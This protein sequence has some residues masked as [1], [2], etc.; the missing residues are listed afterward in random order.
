M[1]EDSAALAISTKDQPGPYDALEKARPKEPWFVL[2]GRDIAGPATLT[3]WARVRRNAALKRYGDSDKATDKELLAAELRQCQNAEELAL[4]FSDYRT[5]AEAP[6][7][8]R[9]SYQEVIKSAEEIAAA[10]RLKRQAAA[11]RHLR[12]AAYHFAEAETL[13]SG[14]G[15]L[16]SDEAESIAETRALINGLAEEHEP[17]RPRSASELEGEA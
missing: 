11:G 6:E 15:R 13:L 12:E 2:L 17:K 7:G 14:L 4:A 16:G 8:E 5:N 9:S 1:T 10:D 3:E